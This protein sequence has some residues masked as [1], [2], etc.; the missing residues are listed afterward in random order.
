MADRYFPNPFQ[1]PLEVDEAD[2]RKTL[3]S[4]VLAGLSVRP[5]HDSI[6]C[7]RDRG[8]SFL[9]ALPVEAMEAKLQ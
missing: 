4:S 3:R 6:P 8:H 9:S 7:M 5:L 1:L 2:V